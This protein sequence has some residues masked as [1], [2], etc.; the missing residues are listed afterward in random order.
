MVALQID[1]RVLDSAE[2]RRCTL[3]GVWLP[4]DELLTIA[5]GIRWC[6]PCAAPHPEL[7][8]PPVDIIWPIAGAVLGAM[9]GLLIAISAG[10]VD[11]SLSLSGLIGSCVGAAVGVGVLVHHE[12]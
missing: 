8:P 1:D 4:A 11:T 9:L 10:A 5:H 7:V 12:F 6:G 3:C 2:L